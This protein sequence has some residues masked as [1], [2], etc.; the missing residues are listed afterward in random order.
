MRRSGHSVQRRES[1]HVPTAAAQPTDA[2]RVL[3]GGHGNRRRGN[4]DV[5]GRLPG[6]GGGGR[7]LLASGSL[8]A[9]LDRKIRDGMRKYGI[10]G[11]A[12]GM[13]Y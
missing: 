11:V 5:P 4:S 2:Q 10:P 12:M 8:F 13:I 9:K 3:T 7:N 6:A 1:G